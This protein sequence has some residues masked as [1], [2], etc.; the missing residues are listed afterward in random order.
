MKGLEKLSFRATNNEDPK[1][2]FYENFLSVYSF[3]SQGSKVY[4]GYVPFVNRGYAFYENFLSVYSFYSQG[5]KVYTG[6][7]PFVNRG[8]AKWVSSLSKMIN[9]NFQT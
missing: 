6:Y 3:Y 9:S 2:A 5:S 4:T 1:G 8:Y 7:V